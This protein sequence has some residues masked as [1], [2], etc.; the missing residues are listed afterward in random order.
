M[1]IC[2]TGSR[3]E[4]PNLICCEFFENKL[5]IELTKPLK[6]TLNVFLGV[7]SRVFSFWYTLKKGCA[8]ACSAVKRTAGSTTSSLDICKTKAVCMATHFQ[9]H[10]YC[11]SLCTS[12]QMNTSS[13]QVFHSV[14]PVIPLWGAKLISALHNH[15]QHQHLFP[16]PE[17]R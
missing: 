13:Y 4:R 12:V 11:L 10:N 3:I 2:N 9:P 5:P 6:L 17:R 14:R 15:P 16:M 8:K 1:L 7:K